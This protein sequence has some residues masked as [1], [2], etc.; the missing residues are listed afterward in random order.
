MFASV[1][2]RLQVPHRLFHPGQR[3]VL[4]QRPHF[5]PSPLHTDGSYIVLAAGQAHTTFVS[6][7]LLQRQLSP[8]RLIALQPLLEHTADLNEQT[9]EE[10]L[11]SR[12]RSVLEEPG[13]R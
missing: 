7:S 8:G 10:V 5:L 11:L 9:L 2:T 3:P 12:P 1:A 6:V 4:G 13:W